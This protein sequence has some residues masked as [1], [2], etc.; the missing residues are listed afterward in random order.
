M[1][2]RFE[3]LNLRSSARSCFS[4]CPS[5]TDALKFF[6]CSTLFT[7]VVFKCFAQEKYLEWTD[8]TGNFRVTAKFVRIEAA[9]VVLL[10][11]DGKEIKVAKSKLSDG[12][13]EQADRE[14][15][16]YRD[17]RDSKMSR[18]TEQR[19]LPPQNPT[20]PKVLGVNER[21][22]L[23][24]KNERKD[25][26][27]EKK[28]E[29]K[30]PFQIAANWPRPEQ[31]VD[32]LG[33]MALEEA[34][35]PLLHSFHVMKK[36]EDNVFEVIIE[37]PAESSGQALIRTTNTVYKSTGKGTLPLVPVGK[38]EVKLKNGFTQSVVIFEEPA[39][40]TATD[41]ALRFKA[42]EKEIASLN[43]LLV[44]SCLNWRVDW[45][46]DYNRNDY[47]FGANEWRDK[48]REKTDYLPN[49]KS[50][51][52]D[53]LAQAKN[54]Y[55]AA[56]KKKYSAAHYAASKLD[57][58]VLSKLA[59]GG[60]DLDQMGEVDI[61][62]L[63]LAFDTYLS[64]TRF[65]GEARIRDFSVE[66]IRKILKTFE[67]S[68]AWISTSYKDGRNL[69][70]LVAV[71]AGGNRN[72]SNI[73]ATLR[74]LNE[75]AVIGDARDK[76]GFTPLQLFIASDL[77]ARTGKPPENYQIMFGSNVE[78]IKNDGGASKIIKGFI[79]CG[80]D[81]N[82]QDLIGNTALHVAVGCGRL[83][84]ANAMMD[85]KPKKSIRNKNNLSAYELFIKAYPKSTNG[86]SPDWL[87]MIE[88]LD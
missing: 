64:M 30:P 81:V 71:H 67:D 57:L 83:D 13:Q 58:D 53:T 86:K 85:A 70:H 7:G 49:R 82:A 88:L 2:N 38:N 37:L 20:D 33:E 8:S 35:L 77:T 61:P 80:S 59:Q 36:L 21:E 43:L 56:E 14:E 73:E 16:Y 45:Y 22:K 54:E 32:K 79:E 60:V 50:W 34:K 23:P 76:F 66:Y 74:V 19:K 84:M 62:P 12:S 72:Y 63:L 24:S 42:R 29:S 41:L 17:L 27:S 68:G 10:K 1:V 4:L 46:G 69:L 3:K 26:S 39:D 6:L 48:V 9:S 11:E 51:P 78:K 47:N 52:L 25:E 87:K 18:S 15:E 31:I 55:Q 5:I 40:I 44:Y 28:E 65:G 75:S